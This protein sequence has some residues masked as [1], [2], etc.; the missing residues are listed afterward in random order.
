[1]QMLTKR[2]VLDIF[3]H[4]VQVVIPSSITDQLNLLVIKV[5]VHKQRTNTEVYIHFL[6]DLMD[7][8]RTTLM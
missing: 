2:S 8:E 7:Q 6:M 4:Q 1:M 5:C 3:V